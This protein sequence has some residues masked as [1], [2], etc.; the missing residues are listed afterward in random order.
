ML[1]RNI[2]VFINNCKSIKS[3][4]ISQCF[5]F[6]L[7]YA[8][9]NL[10][11]RCTVTHMYLHTY[12][13]TYIDACTYICVDVHQY[14]ITWNLHGS[15]VWYFFILYMHVVVWYFSRCPILIIQILCTVQYAVYS[16]LDICS[17][18]FKFLAHFLLRK[19]F[20]CYGI[21]TSSIFNKY[22]THK[23]ILTFLHPL[24]QGCFVIIRFEFLVHFYS[25]FGIG[26]SS[27]HH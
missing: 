9:E 16:V 27:V 22:S 24:K 21:R 5:R 13:R 20:Q 4:A 12:V 25:E 8:G 26:I 14:L 15:L 19:R 10:E 7:M 23:D 6:L 3:S 2:Y 17:L 11:M 18:R 1:L